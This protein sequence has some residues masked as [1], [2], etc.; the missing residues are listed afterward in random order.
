MNYEVTT[1][2]QQVLTSLLVRTHLRADDAESGD[3]LLAL[4][5]M[6]HE[7]AE[8]RTRRAIGSQTRTAFDTAFSDNMPLRG[9]PFSNIVSV[10][11][12]DAD[13]VLTV[14]DPGNYQVSKDLEPLLLPANGYTWPAT[15]GDP[16]AVQIVY[17]CGYSTAP[18]GIVSWMLL[19]IG[20]YYAQRENFV[21]GRV[22]ALPERFFDSLLDAYIVY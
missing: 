20:T 14:I 19:A 15:N 7:Q 11:Y 12:K 2:P 4:T 18:Q 22:A 21:I 13:G 1:P 17:K 9:A 16:D 6:A 3:L 5:G 8:Q 10:S